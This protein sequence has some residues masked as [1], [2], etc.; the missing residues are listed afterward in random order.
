MYDLHQVDGGKTL[1]ECPSGYTGDP[2]VR[3]QLKTKWYNVNVT[4]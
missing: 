4:V 3:C 1:C 2:K